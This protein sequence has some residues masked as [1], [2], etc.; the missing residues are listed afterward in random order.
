MT[1]RHLVARIATTLIVILFGVPMLVL[2]VTRVG[3]EPRHWSGTR[4]SGVDLSGRVPG[5][6]N[7]RFTSMSGTDYEGL[8]KQLSRQPIEAFS[9]GM[10]DPCQARFE[11]TMRWLDHSTFAE[12][13]PYDDRVEVRLAPSSRP[14][15]PLDAAEPYSGDVVLNQ[16]A[17][18]NMAVLSLFTDG[19]RS[20]PG[21]P[22]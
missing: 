4:L 3:L 2:G 9:F 15:G 11:L 19:V 12:L 22:C 13:S 5:C 14:V 10:E 6:P 7:G 16:A 17:G 20:R 8:Y 1:G 18:A 21:T